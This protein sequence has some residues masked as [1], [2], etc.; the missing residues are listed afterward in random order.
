[1]LSIGGC[2]AAKARYDT[3]PD[4]LLCYR[5]EPVRRANVG[6]VFTTDAHGAAILEPRFAEEPCVP[7]VR[8]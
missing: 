7:S 1:L 3:H 5:L 8:Q 6:R 2:L 4:A